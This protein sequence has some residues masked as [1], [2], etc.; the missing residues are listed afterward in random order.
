MSVKNE[1]IKKID[2]IYGV[3]LDSTH[4]FSLIRKYFIDSQGKITQADLDKRSV[5]YGKGHPDQ[6][7]SYFLHRCSQTEFKKRNRENGKNYVTIANLCAVMIYQ[8]W[9]D[10]YREKIAKENKIKKDDV[11]WT[12]M[13]DLRIL[14]HSV[15]HN[16][17]IARRRVKECEILKWFNEGE[18]IYIT[19]DKF[20]QIVRNVKELNYKINRTTSEPIF[21]RIKNFIHKIFQKRDIQK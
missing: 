14:R 19:K 5:Y 2:E 21:I 4:G 10:Y 13:N 20:E 11:E 8:Y 17:G 9:E 3:Y 15:I 18:V 7:G 6:K 12:I 16:K 1:F